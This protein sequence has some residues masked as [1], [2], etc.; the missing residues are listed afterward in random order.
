MC[1]VYVSIKVCAYSILC[2]SI[3]L[4]WVYE[5]VFKDMVNILYFPLSL[6]AFQCSVAVFFVSASLDMDHSYVAYGIVVYRELWEVGFT[7][8]S[9]F[10]ICILHHLLH[11]IGILWQCLSRTSEDFIFFHLDLFWI[12]TFGFAE[13]ILRYLV[14][15]DVVDTKFSSY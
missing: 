12:K 15:L 5:C 10:P 6:S 4:V 2:F 1:L 14:P 13:Y 7:I 11:W 8:S 9:S 3:P